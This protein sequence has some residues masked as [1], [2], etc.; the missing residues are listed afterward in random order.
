MMRETPQQNPIEDSRQR[1]SG[2][3]KLINETVSSIYEDVV[4]IVEAK[5]ELAKIDITKKISVAA[6]MFIL[7]VLLLIG[8]SYLATTIA[9]LLGEL[10]GHLFLGYLLASILFFACFFFFKKLKPEL[11]P[12][13]IQK[14]ILSAH[15][16]R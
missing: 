6:S 7:A 12:S 8:A 16:Y 10:T 11:L 4:T 9:L 13:M 1:E 14:I 15:D 2:I 5:T 3:P